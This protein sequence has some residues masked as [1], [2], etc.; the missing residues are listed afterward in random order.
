[1]TL[2][3]FWSNSGQIAQFADTLG[4][5]GLAIVAAVTL[6]GATVIL[7]LLEGARSLVLGITWSDSPLVRSR[8]VRTAWG[9]AMVVVTVALVVVL[10]TPAPDIV[11]KMF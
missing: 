2:L 4:P 1:V 11:Y 9:T 8:Y 5:V 6:A 7:A 3:W 10:N